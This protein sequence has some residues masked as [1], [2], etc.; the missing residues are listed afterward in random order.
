MT[1]DF[2]ALD[3]IVKI[4]DEDRYAAATWTN[5]GGYNIYLWEPTEKPEDY[6]EKDPFK[7][8]FQGMEYPEG[9]GKWW[10]MGHSSI[11]LMKHEVQELLDPDCK[12]PWENTTKIRPG[13]FPDHED[14]T[15][16]SDDSYITV[17]TRYKSYGNIK[18]TA[19]VPWEFFRRAMIAISGVAHDNLGTIAPL[20]GVIDR[21][22][23]PHWDKVC[24]DVNKILE[25]TLG[26][27]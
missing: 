5:C 20:V 16:T 1:I 25:E 4:D 18:Y 27:K 3:E 22:D 15:V 17:E 2:K 23:L 6:D 21:P 14:I 8:M 13:L 19:K 12:F 9:S 7:Y 10:K 11:H 24:E 26:A